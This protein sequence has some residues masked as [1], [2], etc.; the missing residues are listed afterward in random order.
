[1]GAGC[2]EV[3]GWREDGGLRYSRSCFFFLFFRGV[4]G[5]SS[6]G[7]CCREVVGYESGGL[8]GIRSSCVVRETGNSH[9]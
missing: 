3:M 1:M 7:V 9:P 2:R 4:K 6:M 8:E 5:V